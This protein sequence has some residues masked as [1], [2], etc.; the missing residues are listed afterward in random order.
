MLDWF[1]NNL[2]TLI[3]LAVVAAAVIFAAVLTIK[4]KKKKSACGT[5]CCGCPMSGSCH[6][7]K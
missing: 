7:A 6:K 2:A 3:I 1:L 4:D 5:G